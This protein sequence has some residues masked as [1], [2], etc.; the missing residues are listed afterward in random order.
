MG[1]VSNIFDATE[2]AVGRNPQVTWIDTPAEFL[3]PPGTGTDGANVGV[4][5]PDAV[6]AYVIASLRHKEGRS[7]ALC[8]IV[9]S[10]FLSA[11]TYTLDV[12]GDAYTTTGKADAVAAAADLVTQINDAAV[13]NVRAS[14]VARYTDGIKD[15]VWVYETDVNGGAA[16][17]LVV[18]FTSDGGA[19][20][21]EGYVDATAA[22][23]RL[24]VQMKSPSALPVLAPWVVPQQGDLGAVPA[25]GVTE[26]F[27]VAGF[28]RLY[29]EVY[30]LEKD[31]GHG[32]EMLARPFI[33][34]APAIPEE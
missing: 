33:G 22:K 10:Q 21:T 17:D 5:I 25:G 24:W 20:A 16:A 23:I 2:R 11:T 27:N 32:A 12:D 8:T 13:G 14:A 4:G 18:S 31:P 34:I 15:T 9:R 30:D 28:L 7:S 3:Y 19:D 26:R 6:S 29:V 1:T